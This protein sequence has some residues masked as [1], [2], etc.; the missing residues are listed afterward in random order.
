MRYWFLLLPLLFLPLASGCNDGG[1]SGP[2]A[3]TGDTTRVPSGLRYIT[4]KQGMGAPA[5]PGRSVGVH[6]TGYLAEDGKQF[7]T[8]FRENRGPL[9]FVL[10]AS[11]PNAPIRGFNEGILGM[12][13]GGRRRLF[14]PANLGYGEAGNPPNI[15]ANADLIF[16]VELFSVSSR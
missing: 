8:S 2:P 13:V 7:D 6:Y 5:V 16:D 3:L 10:N 1:V 14:I 4:I 9:T 15:P 11:G 12:S